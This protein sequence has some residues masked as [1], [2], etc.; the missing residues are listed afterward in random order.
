[1]RRLLLVVG[2]FLL[3]SG[4]AFIARQS[5][6][7]EKPKDSQAASADA[8][9]PPEDAARKNPVPVT[10]E[11]LAEARRFYKYQCAMCHNENGDG[12]GELADVMK[13][14]LS[15]W[16]EDSALSAR[17]DGELYYILTNGKGQM[18]GQG[19][20]TKEEMRWKLVNL[21]RSFAK[22][23]SKEK[24]APESPKS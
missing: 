3:V 13:L 9:I 8:K 2:A 4:G 10:A 6:A 11:G 22:K 1:M 21:V 19:D 24:P 17:T 12:K 16:R 15:D 18:V 20:R 23:D 5:N 14:K 7:Q